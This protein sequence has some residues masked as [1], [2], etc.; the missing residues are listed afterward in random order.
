VRLIHLARPGP[1]RWLLGLVLLAAVGQAVHAAG[2]EPGPRVALV[3]GN[4]A[5]RNAPLSNPGNDAKAMAQ[6]LEQL[7]FHVIRVQDGTQQQMFQAVRSFGDALRGGVGLFYFAGHGVQVKGRNF[8][9]P[10]D[11]QIEREDEVPYKA[12]D[13]GLVLE[14]MEAARNPLNIV[15]LDACRNNPFARGLRSAG[16]GGGLAQMDAPSGSLVAFATA[17]GATA[18]DGRGANG[19][20]TSHLLRQMAVPGLPIEEVFKRTRVAVKQE[21]G[22]RQIPWEST[23]LEGAFFFAGAAGAAGQRGL[24]EKELWDVIAGAGTAS[25]YRAYLEKY[26][27]GAYADQAQ[28]RLA[29]ATATSSTRT[30]EAER[31][32]S[33]PPP[34]GTP[35]APGAGFSFSAA[36][37][38]LDRQ[39]SAGRVS[40]AR[41]ALA[42]MPCPPE[43]RRARVQL[44]VGESSRGAILGPA[45]AAFLREAGVRVV[46]QGT[47]EYRV[48]GSAST[49]VGLDWSTGL[50]QV[51]ITSVLELAG[52]RGP[53]LPNRVARDETYAGRD[54]QAAMDEL[55][56]RHAGEWAPQI[57]EAICNR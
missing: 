9:I 33:R 35:A 25:G 20:Y 52:P 10:V 3:I 38:Q 55:V 22:G 50:Q 6:Q 49:Q 13:V 43:R 46:S 54:V 34:P 11:A 30:P 51:S 29:A 53:L 47:S 24:S 7:G 48:R 39:S 42:D 4:A 16:S 15:I 21:S 1:W 8:L 23:S 36:E 31:P 40:A 12:L 17:P 14:K 19:L 57:F 44:Q 18:E 41:R 56:L 45:L 2:A 26:P 5:Y 32:G 28:A 37:A 27:Q